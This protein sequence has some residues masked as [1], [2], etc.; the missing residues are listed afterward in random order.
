MTQTEA[1]CLM[2]TFLTNLYSVKTVIN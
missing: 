2:T 1:V